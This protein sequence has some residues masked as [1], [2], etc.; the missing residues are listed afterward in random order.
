MT[1]EIYQKKFQIFIIM[2]NNKLVIVRCDME[3]FS[4]LSINNQWLELFQKS[5]EAHSFSNKLSNLSDEVFLFE[6]GKKSTIYHLKIFND[7]IGLR[8]SGSLP[9]TLNSPFKV[10]LNV[11]WDNANKYL[12]GI[13]IQCTPKILLDENGIE[14][15]EFT[16][17]DT[18]VIP[19][20]NQNVL[21]RDEFSRTKEKVININTR[22]N[23]VLI[24]GKLK[25]Y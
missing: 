24:D 13:E 8:L 4:N 5:I 7:K 15:V 19:K 6:S 18:E 23:F 20:E 11:S 14:V 16:N 12:Q 2:A 1:Y 21:G 17:T 25:E 22:W 9:K 3:E 10:F